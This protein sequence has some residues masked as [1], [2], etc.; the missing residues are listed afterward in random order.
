MQVYAVIALPLQVVMEKIKFIFSFKSKKI[1]IFDVFC[2]I[3]HKLAKPH[4]G[5]INI[6][7]RKKC[8]DHGILLLA[9]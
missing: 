9:S 3:I 1:I 2:L 7:V 6:L 4:N 5:D 8:I